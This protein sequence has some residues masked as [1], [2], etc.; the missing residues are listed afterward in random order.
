MITETSTISI[1]A[2]FNEKRTH[3]YSLRREWDSTKKSACIIMSNASNADITKG[4]LTGLLIQNN[5]AALGYGAVTV[6][7]LFSYRCQ[8]LNL[9]GDVDI[10]ELTNADNEQ[11]I[12]Q[13][14]KDS[15]ITIIAIGSI[16]TTY[17]KVLPYQNRLYG[18]LRDHQDKIHVICSPCGVEGLHP[19]SSKLRA[20]GSWE[21]VKFTLPEPT[22]SDTDKL[23][24]GADSAGTDIYKDKDDEGTTVD[25]GTDGETLPDMVNSSTSGKGKRNSK[26]VKNDKSKVLPLSS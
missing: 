7:N 22:I 8:K 26:N 14:V 6:T 19:L 3:R 15:D 21:L 18:L 24:D 17:K 25:A 4:D 11:Q 5:L 23:G 16:A 20:D 1:T 2:T 13:A 12:L 9:S 10:A